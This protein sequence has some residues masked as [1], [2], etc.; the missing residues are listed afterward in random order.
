MQPSR[1]RFET[2]QWIPF[3]VELVF[4]FFANPANLVHLTRPGMKMRIEDLRVVPAA[5]RPVAAD[6]ARRFRS[7][8]A[9]VGSE[10]AISF[11]PVAWI[12]LR[13]RWRARIVEFAWNSHFA[14]EQVRGPF[15]AFRHR[16]GIEAE[17][18]E[19]VEGTLVSDRIEFA[20][21]GGRLGAMA[22]GVA[23]GELQR[24]F[25]HRQQR[26][27]ILL[28]DAARQAVRKAGG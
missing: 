8:A 14:D 15:A 24:Q 9:G 17:A 2:A 3:P 6:P 11:R 27:A 18:R 13:L 7:M 23:R 12:P 16:H 5:A 1:G 28:A 22:N 25:T 20:L 26:L 19:G 4:A 21:P 10:I